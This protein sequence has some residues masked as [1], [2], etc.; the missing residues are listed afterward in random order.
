V[1]A[2]K[3]TDAEILAA[4]GEIARTHT[5]GTL[6]YESAMR[7][8]LGERPTER[9]KRVTR[10]DGS[11][12]RQPRADEHGRAW[13]EDMPQARARKRAPRVRGLRVVADESGRRVFPDWG[14]R[15]PSVPVDP[16]T[17]FAAA[18]L[19]AELTSWGVAAGGPHARVRERLRRAILAAYET[20]YGLPVESYWID[21]LVDRL[22]VHERAKLEGREPESAAAILAGLERDMQRVAPGPTVPSWVT[23]EVIAWL[24]GHVSLGGGGG[25]TRKLSAARM[26]E[27]LA[28]GPAAVASE[29][30][31]DA[32][33]GESARSRRAALALVRRLRSAAK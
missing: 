12:E 7:A 14:P 18:R 33:R 4:L 8:L 6:A 24:A 3:R 5:P 1:A 13:E 17:R 30:E 27:L 16:L 28:A 32:R 15:E 29:I 9:A 26:R 25:R 22:M 21:R 20:A 11:Q 2:R 23:S 31:R 10:A 19:V